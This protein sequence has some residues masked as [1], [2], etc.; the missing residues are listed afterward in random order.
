MSGL[1]YL[2]ITAV[3]WLLTGLICWGLAQGG[4]QVSLGQ[5]PVALVSLAALLAFTIQWLAFIPAFI[6]Q[7]ED[8]YDL[9]GSL[10]YLSLLA[11]M[12]LASPELATAKL[13]IVAAV[14][15]WALRL[16]SFLFARAKQYGGDSRFDK[17]KPFFM[18]FF[19][20]WNLQGLWVFLTL[21]GGLTALSSKQ[22]YQSQ[23]DYLCLTIGLTLWLLGFCIEVIADRQKSSFKSDPANHGQ[24]I[25]TGLWSKSR[26]PNYCGEIILWLG[27]ALAASPVLNGWQWLAWISPLF[28]YLLLT[29]VSG[30][31]MLEAKANKTWGDDPQYQQYR[32]NTP[33]LWIKW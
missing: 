32:D 5:H 13:C 33:V 18:R 14:G 2:S 20:T 21:G 15:L 29:R 1:K 25:H 6:F 16:G 28:V 11:L 31:P 23:L 8:Y 26:H 30:L 19:M 12:V 10:T 24:F 9:V 27:I 17:I 4:L 3:I 22:N 7:T